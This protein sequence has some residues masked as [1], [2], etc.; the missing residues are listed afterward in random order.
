MGDWVNDVANWKQKWQLVDGAI[1]LCNIPVKLQKTSEGVPWLA[2]STKRD[3]KTSK[4]TKAPLWSPPIPQ[5]LGMRCITMHYKI[6]EHS[7][8]SKSEA[9][10]FALLQQQDG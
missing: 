4:N 1:C 7:K 2:A 8:N 6:S 9:F 3:G 10:S 5:T